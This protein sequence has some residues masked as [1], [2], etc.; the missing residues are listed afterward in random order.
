MPKIEI[1]PKTGTAQE[2]LEKLRNKEVLPGTYRAIVYPIGR[3]GE[4]LIV[5]EIKNSDTG[6]ILGKVRAT[7]FLHL[8]ETIEEFE[9]EKNINLIWDYHGK[10]CDDQGEN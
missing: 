1:E 7:G 9:K 2:E 6:E 10:Y 5:Y 8:K 4:G 3:C